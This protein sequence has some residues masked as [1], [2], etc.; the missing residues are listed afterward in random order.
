[1]TFTDAGSNRADRNLVVREECRRSDRGAACVMLLKSPV[2]M[3]VV[4]TNPISVMPT[5]LIV[6]PCQPAK[7]NSLLRMIGPPA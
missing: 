7:K 2:R 3:A 4:G 1:M 5:L 6:V